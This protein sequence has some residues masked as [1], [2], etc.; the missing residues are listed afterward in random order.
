[1]CICIYRYI[2]RDRERGVWLICMWQCCL[3]TSVLFL[4]QVMFVLFSANAAGWI[5]GLEVHTH[6]VIFTFATG[7]VRAIVIH[8][9]VRACGRSFIE[10]R[11]VALRRAL[12][13]CLL[14]C[15]LYSPAR[16]PVRLWRVGR[17]D[18]S[19]WDR[20]ASVPRCF[21]V[22]GVI[23]RA[24][25]HTPLFLTPCLPVTDRLVGWR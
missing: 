23:G 7:I 1:M 19:V 12:L 17:I 3:A 9:F 16:V 11:C 6:S 18:F 10:L 15:S 24:C 20:G 21:S 2:P 25:A 5:P 14:S 22:R 4:L 8:V 13:A